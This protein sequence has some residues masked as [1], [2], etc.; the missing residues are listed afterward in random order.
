MARFKSFPVALAIA[1]AAISVV[2]I[3]IVGSTASAPIAS[4]TS[5]NIPDSLPDAQPEYAPRGEIL[6]VTATGNLLAL[7]WSPQF[8]RTKGRSR[9]HDMQCGAGRNFAFILHGLWPDGPKREDPAW[10]RAAPALDRKTVR[11]NFC[12]TPSVDLLQHEWAKHGTCAFKAA[13]DYFTQAARLWDRLHFPD[14]DALSRQQPN[15]GTVRAAL[16]NANPSIPLEA[17]SIRT[18]GGNWLEEVRICYDLSYKPRRCPD[19]DRGADDTRPVK[20]WRNQK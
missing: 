5:C 17:W 6:Q 3:F 1:L 2:L 15:A 8:C 7:S 9:A 16:A 11:A 4:G 13:P 14:M 18:G 19:E 12:R 10:C 20:I